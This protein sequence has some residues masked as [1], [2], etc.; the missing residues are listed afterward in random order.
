MYQQVMPPVPFADWAF[1]VA[2]AEK[3]KEQTGVAQPLTQPRLPVLALLDRLGVEEGLQLAAGDGLVLLAQ[4]VV[5]AGDELVVILAV[6]G[7][8][9]G[10]KDVVGAVGHW[11]STHCD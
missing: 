5:E 4:Q 9:V 6:V 7:A 1:E 8:G 11:K 2:V 3:C 10:E